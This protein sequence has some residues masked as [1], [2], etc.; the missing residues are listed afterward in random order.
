MRALLAW[1]LF[2]AAAFTVVSAVVLIQTS[3]SGPGMVAGTQA[4][5]GALGLSFVAWLAAPAAPAHPRLRIA[6]RCLLLAIAGLT[7]LVVASILVF[8]PPFG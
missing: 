2:A 7:A 6:S 8:R 3:G 1:M 4:W 5:F